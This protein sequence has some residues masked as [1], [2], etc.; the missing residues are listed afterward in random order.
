M[1][2][3]HSCRRI[4]GLVL[5]LSLSCPSCSSDSA[6]RSGGW[7]PN[8]QVGTPPA[9][10]SGGS[11]PIAP[12]TGGALAPGSGGNAGIQAGAGGTISPT[13]GGAGSQVSGSGRGP[14]LPPLDAGSTLHDA[15]MAAGQ[16]AAAHAGPPTAFR[17]S[18]LLV[19]D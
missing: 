1:L 3:S 5:L 11:A 14:G 7:G 10:G 18:E 4:L 8:P 19:R 9:T 12:G 16:D 17:A 2:S 13:S 6:M 15:G